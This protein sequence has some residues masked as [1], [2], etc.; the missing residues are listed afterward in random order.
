M[1][2]STSV[3]G[4]ARS[5]LADPTFFVQVRVAP[6]GRY[7]RVAERCGHAARAALR[8]GTTSRRHGAQ[9]RIPAQP[10]RPSWRHRL[11]TPP[12]SGPT[13]IER[14]E[15]LASE[16]AHS[17][18]GAA[19]SLREGLAETVTL[20]R[21]G[22]HPQLWKML[23]STNPI[24]VDDR[25]LPRHL[26][27]RQALA[28][29]DMHACAGPPP[30]CS[31]PSASCARS[32]LHALRSARPHRRSRHHRNARNT[33]RSTTSPTEPSNTTEPAAA[34]AP[35]RCSPDCHRGSTA[36]GTTSCMPGPR[37]AMM[38]HPR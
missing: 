14:L 6:E 22:V 25:H 36:N 27:K 9:P 18:P 16:L 24:R 13:A 1:W 19:A 3:S 34:L 17:H 7:N 20:Q 10:H 32:S 30:A 15:A 11:Q 29:G 12:R 8:P 23:S 38:V 33:S 26:Q 21:L 28:N 31:K 5:P 4:A 35:A 37:L 2:H